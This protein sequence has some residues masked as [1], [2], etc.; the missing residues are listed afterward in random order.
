MK[1]KNLVTVIIVVIV[2]VVFIGALFFYFNQ[3]NNKINKVLS[4]KYPMIN[5]HQYNSY[6][7]G[8]VNDTM[9]INGKLVTYDFRAEKFNCNN[10]EV[11]P[12]LVYS[13]SPSDSNIDG[14]WASLY[15]V[16]CDDFYLVYSFADSGPK[17][18]GP[19]TK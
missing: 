11:T 10:K 18:Y 7:I 16:D 5:N 4:D 19:F 15:I 3:N 13:Y 12:V 9:N 8:M 17:L 14:G 6:L 1:T 2:L